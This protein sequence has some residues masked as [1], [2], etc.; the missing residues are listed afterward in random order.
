MLFIKNILS[1]SKDNNY[2]SKIVNLVF[3][4]YPLSFIL[5]NVALNINTIVLVVVSSIFYF[6]KSLFKQNYF[7]SSKDIFLIFFYILLVM[8]INFI[9]LRYFNSI[10]IT[11]FDNSNK[12]LILKSL[13]FLR[14][15]FLYLIIKFLIVNDIIDFK[16]F[17]LIS[18]I[19]CLFVCFD[20][21]IQFVF[22]KDLFGYVPK[23]P[24][25]LSGPFGP[26]AIAGGY[27]QKFFIFMI[28]FIF[29]LKTKKKILI[30]LIL[31]SI[32]F[33]G[34]I[35][36]GNRMPFVM[37]VLSIFLIFIFSKK[38]RKYFIIFLSL[39]II[40]LAISYGNQNIRTNY[41]TFITQGSKILIYPFSSNLKRNNM[42]EYFDEFETFYDTWQL[43]KFFG[44]G[45]RSFRIF[46][47][48]R[49]NID[50][51]E[52]FSCNTHPHNY[53]L[54]IISELGLFGILLFVYFFLKN[55]KNSFDYI[56]LNKNNY[57]KKYLFLPFFILFL[58]EIFPLKNTGSFFSTWNATFI[59][60]VIACLQGLIQANKNQIK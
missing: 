1:P 50:P 36:S 15:F 58:I 13:F 46:C 38:I 10:N 24:R 53:Y 41:Q 54:E 29:L 34:I 42:P 21:F 55:I 19:F 5:G 2:Q 26:E 47:P 14:F 48:Y 4:T 12:Y 8:I 16:K 6:K 37:S 35:L 57:K 45:V 30:L 23:Y 40:L 39:I 49:K 17:F 20:I 51:D 27:I 52:R 60:I 3:C 7:N 44:G 33:L 43:N 59:F 56:L 32:S 31:A 11:H 22:N 18:S 28:Y 9:D 25:K